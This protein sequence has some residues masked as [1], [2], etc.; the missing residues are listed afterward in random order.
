MIV[1]S[2]RMD[3]HLNASEAN[4]LIQSNQRKKTERQRELLGTVVTRNMRSKMVTLEP[5]WPMQSYFITMK[6]FKLSISTIN[7]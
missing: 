1:I 4:S 2:V 3:L 7:K 5:H 6:S